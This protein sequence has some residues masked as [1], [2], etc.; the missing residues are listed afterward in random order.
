MATGETSV[1]SNTTE[2]AA[3][4]KNKE[5]EVHIGTTFKKEGKQAHVALQSTMHNVQGKNRSF[6]E[7][8]KGTSDEEGRGFQDL[9]FKDFFSNLKRWCFT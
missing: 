1:V 3:T 4:H 7:V 6:G 2:L 9:V 8:M 5:E